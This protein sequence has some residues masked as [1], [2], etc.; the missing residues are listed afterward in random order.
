MKLKSERN[1]LRFQVN[2]LQRHFEAAE[3]D[4]AARL[5]VIE[6]QGQRLGQVEAERDSLRFQLTD[7]QTRLSDARNNLQ[8]IQQ[9]LVESEEIRGNQL[10]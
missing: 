7:L 1:D 10:A 5:T 9:Q 2:D 3:A 6:E 4:R 8:Q